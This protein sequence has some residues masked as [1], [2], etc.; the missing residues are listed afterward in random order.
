MK[1]N[2]F[3]LILMLSLCY[4]FAEENSKLKQ[5]SELFNQK[6]YLLVQKQLDDISSQEFS[7][8][9]NDE[10]LFFVIY[11]AKTK[12]ELYKNDSNYSEVLKDVLD[13]LKKYDVNLKNSKLNGIKESFFSTRLYCNILLNNIDEAK[14]DYSKIKNPD[15]YCSYLIAYGYFT[16]EK[17]YEKSKSY[18]DNY[19][20][21]E[22]QA[23]F[24]LM[25]TKLLYAKNLLHMNNVSDASNIYSMLYEEHKLSSDDIFEYAKI[26]FIQEKYQSAEN[27]ALESKNPLMNYFCGLCS[28]NTRQ[29]DKAEKY[30]SL[31]LQKNASIYGYLDSASYYKAYAVYRMGKYKEAYKLFTTFADSTTELTFARHAY[32]IAAKCAVYESDFKNASIQAEKLVKISF[33]DDDKQKAVIFCA[34]IYLDCKEYD[35]AYELLLPYTYDKSDFSLQC[36]KIIAE[37][38]VKTNDIERAQTVYEKIIKTYP[39]TQDAQD[40]YFKRAELYYANNNFAKAASFYSDYISK[41]SNGSYLEASYYFCGES[42]LKINEYEKCVNQ[43]KKLISKY[44]KSIYTYGAYKNLFTAYYE[45]KNFV[46]A[47]KCA[48]YMMSNFKSQAVSDGIPEKLDIISIVKNGTSKEIA[49]KKVEFEKA[50]GAKK[51]EGRMIGYELFNLYVESDN[52]SEAKKLADILYVESITRD[53]KEYYY[54][55]LICE[56]YA[57]NES[58]AKQAQFYLKAVEFYRMSSEDTSQKEAVAL[59]SAV[60]AFLKDNKTADA[61][62]TA[63]VL[64]KLYPESRQAKNVDKLF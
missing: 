22:E 3:K 41:Y 43:N 12:L 52:Y 20:Q 7:E 63:Q 37:I 55:G 39:N 23:S 30:L 28:I 25:E 44:P 26:L 60:D 21:K 14:D 13:K 56:F 45:L 35:K 64:K 1:K 17:D 33:K 10:Q 59:Y 51:L 11:E 8:F 58:G 24:K 16:V 19:L 2:L 6:Q 46:E 54:L 53:K 29:W 62:E 49:E 40:A 15:E 42:Y 32:E 36:Y 4:L 57:K 31:Y 9:T 48:E 38:Y 5:I 47:E 18:L 61:K 50:G 34:E 27:K